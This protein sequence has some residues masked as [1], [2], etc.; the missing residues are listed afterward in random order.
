MDSASS[1]DNLKSL[2]YNFRPYEY[3]NLRNELAMPPYMD[4]LPAFDT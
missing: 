2:T 3:V 1:H 4:L